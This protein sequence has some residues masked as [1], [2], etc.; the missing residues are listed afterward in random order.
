MIKRVRPAAV[1]IVRHPTAPADGWGHMDRWRRAITVFLLL[2]AEAAGW[3]MAGYQGLLLP[4]GDCAYF[5]LSLR[6]II[7]GKFLPAQ[8][9]IAVPRCCIEAWH[10]MALQA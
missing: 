4:S 7:G 6:G 3:E 9:R 1:I 5:I 10:A 8:R 2:I